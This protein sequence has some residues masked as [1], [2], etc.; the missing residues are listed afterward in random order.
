MNRYINDHR[1]RSLRF[2]I[3]IFTHEVVREENR[4]Y[5]G[6]LP[7]DHSYFLPGSHTHACRVYPGLLAQVKVFTFLIMTESPISST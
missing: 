2:A 7:G 1:Y 4:R 5:S 6:C 3:F